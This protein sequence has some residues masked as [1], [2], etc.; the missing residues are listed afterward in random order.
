MNIWQHFTGNELRIHGLDMTAEMWL[1]FR[2][3]SMCI[4][5]QFSKTWLGVEICVTFKSA[6][7]QHDSILAVPSPQHVCHV[8]L[9]GWVLSRSSKDFCWLS[10]FNKPRGF[11]WYT[12]K[13]FILAFRRAVS[14][15]MIWKFP[16]LE[17]PMDLPYFVAESQKNWWSLQLCSYLKVGNFSLVSA[18]SLGFPMVGWYNLVGGSHC[19]CSLF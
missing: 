1:I 12:R 14:I 19:P 18:V 13:L 17:F 10:G 6:A 2:L 5:A 16:L 9:N 11:G 7:W 15:N 8:L 3:C 4:R